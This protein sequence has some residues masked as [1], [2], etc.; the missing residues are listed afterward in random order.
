[1]FGTN[2]FSNC[3]RAVFMNKFYIFLQKTVHFRS[4]SAFLNKKN[5]E[6]KFSYKLGQ[7]VFKVFQVLAQFLDTK[8]ETELNYYHQKL[9][10]LV[11]SQ[12]FE[13]PETKH[14]R[15]LRSF[16]KIFEILQ[17]DSEYPIS[18]TKHKF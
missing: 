17:L 1:M 12:V 15:K 10:V 11:A 14:S 16:K 7:N 5:L 13:Q 9:I 18:Q 6:G 3:S 8:S 2:R 4:F